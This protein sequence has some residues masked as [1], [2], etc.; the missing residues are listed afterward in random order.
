MANTRWLSPDLVFFLP[1]TQ[2]GTSPWQSWEARQPSSGQRNVNG[3]DAT[4]SLPGLPARPF[5]A[6]SSVRVLFWGLGQKGISEV[7]L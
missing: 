3:R 6:F 7:E 5:R 1:V 4:P 2:L